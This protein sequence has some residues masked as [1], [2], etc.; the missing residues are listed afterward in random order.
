VK[1]ESGNP[2]GFRRGSKH[3]ATLLAEQL[4]E[5]EASE[6][7]RTVI[8]LAKAGDTA[9]LKICVDRI[10]PPLKSRAVDFKLPTLGSTR[11]ALAALNLLV[12][13]VVTGKLLPESAEPL[14]AIVSTFIKAVEI[15]QVEDR[16]CELEKARADDAQREHEGHRYD[17]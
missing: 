15:G 2:A 6:L 8:N 14:A 3:R 16:L 12:Q 11:D 17:A 9:A 5:G 1:G 10:L 13:G 7:I 4:F